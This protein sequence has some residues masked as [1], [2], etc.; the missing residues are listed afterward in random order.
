MWDGASDR[1]YASTR[2]NGKRAWAHRVSY[3]QF[4]GPIPSG[5]EI[6]HLC[7]N[8]SCTN[9]E[10]LEAVSHAV[11]MS[12][13]AA[14][15]ATSCRSGHEYTE[16]NT[17]HQTIGNGKRRCRACFNARRRRRGASERFRN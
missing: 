9:P 16:A 14:A 13:S 1:G 17:I 10:H 6:D 11:N 8:R 12:R 4:V 2:V 5:L 3:E 7:R 15:V